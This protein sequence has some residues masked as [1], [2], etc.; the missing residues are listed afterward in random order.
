MTF[1][2]FSSHIGKTLK[3]M[4]L[5]CISLVYMDAL[6]YLLSSV[7]QGVGKNKIVDRFLHL[8]NRPR[9]Y[10][11]LHRWGYHPTM[12][13]MSFHRYSKYTWRFFYFHDTRVRT[14]RNTFT[15][16]ATETFRSEVAPSSGRQASARR[17]PCGWL[18]P[19]SI[20]HRPVPRID[21]G[22]NKKATVPRRS[23]NGMPIT[24]P[25][26]KDSSWILHEPESLADW[27]NT[28]N[29]HTRI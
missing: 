2:W 3:L 18:K 19:G 22:P 15:F 7:S 25:R 27:L 29:T 21:P 14:S 17:L 26:L 12:C 1:V 5:F 20:G 9:E 4:W 28:K 13:S 11:Q 10:L 6:I 23:R 8:L 24:R 16:A